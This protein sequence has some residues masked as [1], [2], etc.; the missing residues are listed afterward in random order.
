MS[1]SGLKEIGNL[2]E[3]MEKIDIGENIKTMDIFMNE[4][5]DLFKSY[6]IQDSVIALYHVLK[7]EESSRKELNKFYIPIS[8]ASFA[9]KYLE[10]KLNME[11]YR[12][13]I[14]SNFQI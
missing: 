10:S 12:I 1:G 2:Y 9:R 13:P 11:K 3:N 5:I 7:V 6:A 4:N 8:I 14:N